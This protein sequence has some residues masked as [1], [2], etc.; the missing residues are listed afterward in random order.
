MHDALIQ[1]CPT[2]DRAEDIYK[3]VVGPANQEGLH[4]VAEYELECGHTVEP[5]KGAQ[6]DSGVIDLLR[7]ANP[8]TIEVTQ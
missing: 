3:A 6:M 5:D 4:D 1:Y 2:C 8:N 7:M